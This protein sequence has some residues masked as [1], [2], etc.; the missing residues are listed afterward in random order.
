[1]NIDGWDTFIRLHGGI[2]GARDC[3]EQVCAE[4]LDVVYSGKDVHRIDSAGGDGG[5]DMYVSNGDGT[6]D[7]YQC[8]FFR[9]SLIPAKWTQIKDSFRKLISA[10]AELHIR[11]WY[12]CLP[13]L[14][15]AKEI[16]GY[17]KFKKS[18]ETE[19]IIIKLLD[20]EQLITMITNA[21]LAEKWF[22]PQNE[23][24]G[25]SKYAVPIYLS[26]PKPFNKLQ[27]RFINLLW[28]DLQRRG[29]IPRNMGT[30]E[31]SMEAPL[32]AISRIIAESQGCLCVAFRRVYI[33]K[34]V[35]KKGA[36]VEGQSADALNDYW[37]TSPYSHIEP[38]M[39]YQ[40]KLP[41]LF[42]KEKGV[43]GEGMLETSS[44]SPYIPEF[45]LSAEVSMEDFFTSREYTR[46]IEDFAK[47][48]IRTTKPI[49]IDSSFQEFFSAENH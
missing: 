34:A 33:E 47:R 8:K 38:A 21:G 12:L 19:G 14:L 24:T 20:G 28:E 18:M 29:F 26:Y 39:A 10:H 1:M 45:E 27:E 25:R 11:T 13:K 17:E 41:I 43:R 30:S 44:Q 31:Y 48:V 4:M 32:V 22:A 2:I 42:F 36:N 23:I 9:D 46:I 37:Y 3:F 6:V 16:E 40:L 35:N 7:I 5:I 15:R 49:E